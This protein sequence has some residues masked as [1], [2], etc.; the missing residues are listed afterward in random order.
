[1][2]IQNRTCFRF[3]HDLETMNCRKYHEATGITG[4]DENVRWQYLLVKNAPDQ[5]H[6]FDKESSGHLLSIFI[7]GA[8]P[9]MNN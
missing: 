4:L 3:G 2:K 6:S 8:R 5:E 1:M 9:K 7:P